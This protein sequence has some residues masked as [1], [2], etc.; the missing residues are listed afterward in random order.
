MSKPGSRYT[1]A[2]PCRIECVG[3]CFLDAWVLFNGLGLLSVH[4]VLIAQDLPQ[5]SWQATHRLFLEVSI[6]SP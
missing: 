3:R 6:G 5:G 1:I 4:S 2:F